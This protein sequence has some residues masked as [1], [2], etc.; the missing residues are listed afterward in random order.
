MGKIYKGQTKLN[1]Q[2]TVGT[3]ITGG[4][5][6]IRY[7]KPDGNKGEFSASILSATTGIITYV[8]TDSTDLDVVG[9]W[10]FWGYVTFSDSRVAAGEP[11]ELIIHQ[12]GT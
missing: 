7:V 11:F 10:V 6:V 4:N 8:P 3:D 5:A 9:T 12:E 1:L 2:V